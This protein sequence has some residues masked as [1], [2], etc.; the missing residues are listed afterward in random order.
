MEVF[1]IFNVQ[2]LTLCL[3]F[4]F[5]YPYFL[6]PILTAFFLHF[7]YY[8]LGGMEI[9]YFY[10]TTNINATD[11]FFYL[12][13]NINNTNSSNHLLFLFTSFYIFLHS[14]SFFLLPNTNA[15][16]LY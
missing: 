2:L 11:C 9:F 14:N 12:Y 15:Y 6:I 3:S 13:P 8:C 4:C 1:F 5:I 10:I 7:S 16:Y